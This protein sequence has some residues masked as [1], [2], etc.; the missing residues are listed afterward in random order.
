[1]AE[2]CQS[3]V[4]IFVYAARYLIRLRFWLPSRGMAELLGMGPLRLKN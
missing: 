4:T 1:M 2:W 3:E